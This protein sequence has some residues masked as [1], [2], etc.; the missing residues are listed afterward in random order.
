MRRAICRLAALLLAAATCLLLGP[1]V[2]HADGKL[3]PL[4][5]DSSFVP[6]HATP[7]STVFERAHVRFA[8][9]KFAAVVEL[10]RPA[11]A[12]DAVDP[13]RPAERTAA[14]EMLGRS[15]VRTG[16]PEGGVEAF[17]RLLDAAPAW[18]ML[19]QRVQ[20]DERAVFARARS[21]WRAAHP[22][23]VRAEA[24]AAAMPVRHR[25]WYRQRRF[26]AA[27]GAALLG[28]AAEILRHQG[29]VKGTHSALPDLPG[30]P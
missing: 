20:D 7:D 2:A 25:A 22:D 13:V 9:A 28:V 24:A 6:L 4:A 10:L 5:P 18:T 11:L 3:L 21:E 19:P 29:N 16:D 26:Q 8:R 12:A 17:T 14:L 27:G 1:R 23:Y 30:H 15:L